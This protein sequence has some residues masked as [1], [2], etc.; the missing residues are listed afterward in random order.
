MLYEAQLQPIKKILTIKPT[1]KPA[2]EIAPLDISTY[3][4]VNH[5]ISIQDARGPWKDTSVRVA[6]VARGSAMI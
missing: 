5:K 4:E 2:N 1:N 6:V 3:L